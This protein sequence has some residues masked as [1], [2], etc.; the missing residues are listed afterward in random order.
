MMRETKCQ[1][2]IIGRACLGRPWLFGELEDLFAGKEARQAPNF[3]EIRAIALRH[4]ALLVDFFGQRLGIVHM[5]KFSTWYTKSFQGGS[6]LRNKLTRIENIDELTRLLAEIPAETPFPI[7]GLR[8]HRGKRGGRQKV[9]LPPGF[10]A[11]E[12]CSRGSHGLSRSR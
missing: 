11:S 5:R 8:V 9:S 3:G 7:E 6:A 4:A 2:V 10:F 1:G 12:L